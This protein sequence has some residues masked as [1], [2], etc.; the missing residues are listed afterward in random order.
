MHIL[1]LSDNFP[2]EVNAP[3]SRTF[4]HCREWVRCGHRVT[5]ITCVPNF[6]RGRVFDGYRNRLCQRE[7]IDGIEVIRV[8][9]YITANEG[10]FRRTLDYISFMVSATLA[11][12]LVRHVDIV[13]ATSPQFFTACAGLIVSS[14]KRTPFVFELRDLWPDSIRAVG[15]MKDGPVLR[16]LERLE[17]FLYRQA[18]AIVTVTHSFGTNLMGRGIDGM[19]ISVVT[20]GA[21]LS[22]FSPRPKDPELVKRLGL[23]DKVVAGYIGTHGM[24][25]GLETVLDAAGKLAGLPGGDEVHLLLLGDGAMKRELKVE[26][27]RRGLRNVT[28]LDTVPKTEVVRYWSLIDVSII[29]LKKNELFTTVIPS[30]L[31]ESMAMGIPTLHGVAGESARIVEREEVGL[32][33]EPENGCELAEKLVL[34]ARDESLRRALSRRCP[35]AAKRYDRTT[36]AGTMLGILEEVVESGRDRALNAAARQ[37]L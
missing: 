6:P 16:A 36:L 4:E 32:V 18:S 10:F 26:A 17:L 21:D 1:F 30:K 34:L 12:P 8:W 27:A 14:A 24:A 19:K 11:S 20:N 33:F 35:E 2:P 29:H 25:H 37:R 9:S 3:A 28:F 15:A 23:Q 31:F 22:R 13:I 5:L 7:I